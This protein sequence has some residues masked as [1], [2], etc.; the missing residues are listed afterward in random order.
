MAMSEMFTQLGSVAAGI[1]F[2]WDMFQQYFLYQ[3]RPHIQKYSQK[4][5]SFVY[6]YIQI[7]VQE[8]S[9]N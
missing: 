3:L 1:M 2:L 8:Y 6:P 9:E 5:V 7:T 4:L